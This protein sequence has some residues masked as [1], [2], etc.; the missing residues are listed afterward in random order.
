MNI[1]LKNSNCFQQIIVITPSQTFR[2]LLH[3]CIQSY[4]LFF[5]IIYQL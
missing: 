5:R 4:F 1:Q 3:Q 2:C